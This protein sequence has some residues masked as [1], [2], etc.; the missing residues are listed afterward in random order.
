M[1]QTKTRVGETYKTKVVGFED[2]KD[3]RVVKVLENTAVCEII[4]SK[5]MGLVKLEDLK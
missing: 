3:V 2:L 1:K 5:E 4:E